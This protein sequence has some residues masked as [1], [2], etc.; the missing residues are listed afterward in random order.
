MTSFVR[1]LRPDPDAMLKNR[2]LYGAYLLAAVLFHSFYT[3]W[4]SLY[5]LIFSLVLPVFSFLISLPSMRRAAYQAALPE[6]CTCAQEAHYRLTAAHRA[7]LPVSLCRVCLTVTDVLSGQQTV[8]KLLLGGWQGADLLVDTRHAGQQR[9]CLTHARVY[10]ALGLICLRL[11]LPP[12]R[13]VFVQPQPQPPTQRPDLS[14]FQFHSYQPKHGGGFSEV[15]ELREY[16][17]GDALRDIRWKLSAK[18]DQLIVREAQ[19]PRPGTVVL[20]FDFSGSRAQLD[21]TLSQLLWLSSYLTQRQVHH[22]I[23]WLDPDTLAPQSRQIDAPEELSALLQELLQTHLTGD[24]PSIASR[25]YAGADWRYHVR[26][27]GQ[28]AAK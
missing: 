26:P 8:H 2:L 11:P 21:S 23:D 14:R 18:T 7:R 3:G 1:H 6:R 5:L 24:T 9:F 16:R 15:H 20:S 17:P 27:E 10:D 4:F 22:Q 25:S 28:E 13:C 12:E 19:Q